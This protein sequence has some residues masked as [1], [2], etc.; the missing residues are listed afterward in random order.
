MHLVM[1]LVDFCPL[2]PPHFLVCCLQEV[3]LI[4]QYHY[5]TW[6]DHDKP[7]TAEPLIHMLDDIREYQKRKET[8]IVVHCRYESD[9]IS[10]PLHCTCVYTVLAVAVLVQ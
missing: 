10:L 8:P 2:P 9:M 6:P 7:S 1:G 3:Q 4:R 5:H